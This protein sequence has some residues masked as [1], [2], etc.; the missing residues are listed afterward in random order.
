MRMK[1]TGFHGTYYAWGIDPASLFAHIVFWTPWQL[2]KIL[3]D[4]WKTWKR[5]AQGD[6]TIIEHN[7][8]STSLYIF[9][10]SCCLITPSV[11]AASL[12]WVLEPK[13]EFS[14]QRL[15][16][17]P[18]KEVRISSVGWGLPRYLF[19]LPIELNSLATS[20]R[21]LNTLVYPV[22]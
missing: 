11:P 15:S 17:G 22:F 16:D 6:G 8:G 3:F 14:D 10:F 12:L 5:F 19:F 13:A 21:V 9:H 4:S 20:S 1:T 18:A 7:S 2:Y